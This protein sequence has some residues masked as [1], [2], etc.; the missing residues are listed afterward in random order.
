MYSKTWLIQTVGKPQVIIKKIGKTGANV[1]MNYL[2]GNEIQRIFLIY[3][4]SHR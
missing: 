3:C 1:K 4:N 2:P